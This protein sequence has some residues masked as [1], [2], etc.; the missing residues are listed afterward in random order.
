MTRHQFDLIERYLEHKMS[1]ADKAA[2][3]DELLRDP[4]LRN[5]F[6]FQQEIINSL[7][8]YRKAEIKSRLD[9][10]AVN[11]SPYFATVAKIA[12]SI[13]V[14]SLMIWGGHTYLK[15]QKPDVPQVNISA[16]LP[17]SDN[18]N[19]IPARPEVTI[20]AQDDT[21]ASITSV[22]SLPKLRRTATLRRE[23]RVPEANIPDMSETFREAV[24]QFKDEGTLKVDGGNI[25][26]DEGLVEIRVGE[27]PDK[28]NRYYYQNYDGKLFLYGDFSKAPYVLME[29]NSDRERRLFLHYNDQYYHIKPNQKTV[30]PLLSIKDTT[31]IRQLDFLKTDKVK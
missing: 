30:S 25:R 12:A 1:A 15:S 4:L 26:R 6:E 11:P 17:V 23:I 22:P 7:K 5:E 14:S 3:E 2:F 24:P 16:E 21:Q 29:L 31:L 9:N 8:S 20:Q 28:K 10:I 13:A 19:F 18:D 27:S